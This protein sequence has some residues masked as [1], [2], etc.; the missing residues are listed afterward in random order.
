MGNYTAFIES[1]PPPVQSV[2]GGLMFGATIFTLSIVLLSD[3][4]YYIV[5]I[6]RVLKDDDPYIN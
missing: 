1:L 5:R 2:L 4:H 6:E 3:M